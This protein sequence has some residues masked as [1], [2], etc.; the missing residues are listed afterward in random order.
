M[1]EFQ[2]V[3][4]NEPGTP[5]KRHITYGIILLNTLVLLLMA[6]NGINF[7]KPG[8]LDL[9][10]WG[11][12]LPGLT[13][14]GEGWRLVTNIFLH[15]GFFHLAVNMFALYFIGSFM[16]PMLGKARYIAGYLCTG[17]TA[18]LISALWH[19]NELIVSAGA[20]GAIMGLAGIFISLLTTRVIPGQLRMSWLLSLSFFVVYSIIYGLKPDSRTDNAVHLGGLAS[21]LVIGYLYYF[22]FRRP[23]KAKTRLI[24]F[25]ALLSIT[26]FVALV[27]RIG[28]TPPMEIDNK[29]GQLFNPA[30]RKLAGDME[31]F[32]RSIEHFNILDEMAAEAAQPSDTVPREEFLIRLRETALVDLVECVNLMDEA[33]TLSLTAGMQ[34]LR[35]DLRRYANCR[36]QETQW[37]I[38]ANEQQ[39]NKYN[40]SI[41]SIRR[42]AD[43]IMIK[44]ED[45]YQPVSEPEPKDL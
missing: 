9:I 19:R 8:S 16:E 15:S 40:S 42:Q 28:Q 31:R 39:T 44:I 10:G 12:N 45:E 43:K 11:G 33:E 22:T 21:G 6:L 29:T 5:G 25:L 13:F 2:A 37:L 30:E 20:S 35:A 26:L 24:T 3:P 18:S 1:P 36:I 23:S 32:S 7:F 38:K 41:D 14:G 34:V 27:V 17:I 4:I